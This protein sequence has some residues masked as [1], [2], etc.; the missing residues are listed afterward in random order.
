MLNISYCIC[1]RKI[2]EEGNEEWV[3]SKTP[4]EVLGAMNDI[5]LEAKY[6]TGCRSII[7]GVNVEEKRRDKYEHLSGMYRD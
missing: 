3:E 7:E 5:T 2:K 1:C 6:C 4:L